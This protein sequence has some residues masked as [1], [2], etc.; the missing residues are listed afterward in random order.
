MVER[1]ADR[2][3]SSDFIEKRQPD[4]ATAFHG[5]LLLGGS[6]SVVMNADYPGMRATEMRNVSM[7]IT[8]FYD[9]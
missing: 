2:A 5:S 1:G 9:S 6:Q 8:P 4:L 3:V 7:A